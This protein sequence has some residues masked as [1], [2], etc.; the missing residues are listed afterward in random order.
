[1]IKLTKL[2]RLKSR[3]EAYYKAE[4][5]ILSGQEYTMGSRSLRRADLKTVQS[6]IKALEKEI[7][8]LEKGGKNKVIRGIPLDI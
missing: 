5:A 3:L 2:E 6:E 4:T 7:D 8:Y 1:M